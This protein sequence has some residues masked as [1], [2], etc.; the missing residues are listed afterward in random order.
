VRAQG[1]EPPSV[2]GMAVQRKPSIKKIP[3]K[4]NGFQGKKIDM[5]SNLGPAGPT[6]D[7]NVC[8][9]L[10]LAWKIIGTKANVAKLAL[11]KLIF[12]LECK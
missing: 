2:Q 5:A 7:D 6:R 3:F 9:L 8:H 1:R 11:S 12:V 4:L 10:R